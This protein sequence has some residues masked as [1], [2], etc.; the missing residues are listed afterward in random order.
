MEYSEHLNLG[1]MEDLPSQPSAKLFVG[2]IPKDINEDV[3]GSYFEDFG[4]IKELSIIRDTTT[5][6]SRGL[7]QS[8]VPVSEILL[9]S[10][11]FVISCF[12]HY[13]QYR[14]CFCDFF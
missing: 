10:L 11:S 14:L 7:L 6:M 8:I 13:I 2:Q 1:S 4:A 12:D 5:G 9:I 3:L